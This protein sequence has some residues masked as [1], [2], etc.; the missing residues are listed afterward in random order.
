[1]RYKMHLFPEVGSKEEFLPF[2]AVLALAKT[3][4]N[5]RLSPVI[6]RLRK[7]FS[8][9]GSASTNQLRALGFFTIYE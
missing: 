1:M 6:S 8:S 2:S 5:S 9:S 3:L 7:A 4:L